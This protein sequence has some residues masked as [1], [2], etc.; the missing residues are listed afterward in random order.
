[1]FSNWTKYC[2][3][4]DLAAFVLLKLIHVWWIVVHCMDLPVCE[5]VQTV[6]NLVKAIKRKLPGSSSKEHKYLSKRVGFHLH[7]N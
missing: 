6:L 4:L 1:M 5:S 2:V 7:D 3:V